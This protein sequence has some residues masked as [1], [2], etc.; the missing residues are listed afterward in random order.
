MR[1]GL[2]MGYWGRDGGAEPLRLALEAERLGYDVVWAAEAYGSDAVTVLS[3]LAARTTRLGLGSAVMQIPARTPAMTGMTAATLDTLSEGRFQLG[4]GVSGPQVSAGWHGVEFGKPLGRTREYIEVVRSVVRRELVRHDGEH[5]PL[6]LPGPDGRP[7]KPLKLI[8]Q[9]VRAEIP[10]YL[11]A[12]G[13]RNVRL[14]GEIADGWLA[15]FYAPSHA[16]ENLAQ[17]RAGRGERGLTGFDIVAT[18]PVSVG[19]DLEACADRVRDYVA[20]YVGGMGPRDKNS[21]NAKARALGYEKEAR[22]VQ[23]LYLYGDTEGAAAAVPFGLID[24]TSLLGP[25]DR[26]ADRLAAFAASGVTTLSITPYGDTYEEKAAAL[27]AVAE[28]L[29]R[30]NI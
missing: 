22:F 1:L 17:L 9:S 26:I 10:V 27:A 13:P 7:G 12:V 4:L 16:D 21:Y 11:A 14:A 3:W 25:V 24:E 15:I 20:L 19:D 30:A 18:V 8:I 29:H 5:Y 23:D 28:A 6:P 2:N